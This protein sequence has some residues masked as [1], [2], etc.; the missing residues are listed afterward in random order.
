MNPG[1]IGFYKGQTRNQSI[2][3]DELFPDDSVNVEN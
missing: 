1:M 2:M 3:Q